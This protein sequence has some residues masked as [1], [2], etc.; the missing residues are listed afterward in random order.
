MACWRAQDGSGVCPPVPARRAR[1]LQP[2]VLSIWGSDS[3]YY[4]ADLLEYIGQEFEE[5]RPDLPDDWN[6]QATV[7]YW[8]DFL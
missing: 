2:P 4:G 6:P 3:I 8:R 7:A 1:N 5:P